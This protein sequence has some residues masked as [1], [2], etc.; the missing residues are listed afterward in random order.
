M[1]SALLGRCHPTPCQSAD[2]RRRCLVGE[3]DH[4]AHRHLGSL[5]QAVSAFLSSQMWG[6]R[7]RHRQRVTSLPP[8]VPGLPLSTA[9]AFVDRARGFCTVPSQPGSLFP[10]AWL[11]STPTLTCVMSPLALFCSAPAKWSPPFGLCGLGT[12]AEDPGSKVPAGLFFFF[13][14]KLIL[15]VVFPNNGDLVCCRC[16]L[17]SVRSL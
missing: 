16:P 17:G 2:A 15:R 7:S 10:N 9:V 5:R 3:A 4:R 14:L 1:R 8:I 13:F 11:H 6:T 12:D